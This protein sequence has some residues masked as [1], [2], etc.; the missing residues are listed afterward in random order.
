MAAIS[1]DVSVDLKLL[2]SDIRGTFDKARREALIE[3]LQG[4]QE[5]AQ[6]A[7]RFRSKTHRLLQSVKY[8]VHGEDG[9]VYL[10]ENVAPYAPYFHDG[11]GRYGERHRDI[12]IT[13]ENGK[14]LHWSEGGRQHFASRVISSGQPGELFLY[15]AA[16]QYENSVEQAYDKAVDKALK[17]VF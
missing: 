9:E 16:A 2:K 3:S 13:P 8:E 14:A 1:V 6:A 10:D 15:D 12:I 4:I 17:E 11:T 5:A 7:I